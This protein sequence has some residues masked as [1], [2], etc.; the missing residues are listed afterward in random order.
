MSAWFRTKGGLCFFSK[1]VTWYLPY[2]L[3]LMTIW[4]RK[5]VLVSLWWVFTKVSYF[6]TTRWPSLK[7]VL[8]WSYIT[9]FSIF[10]SV[11]LWNTKSNFFDIIIIILIGLTFRIK[12]HPN[13]DWF[14]SICGKWSIC[15]RSQKVSE[16]NNSLHA[17]SINNICWI[18]N[19][20]INKEW[21]SHS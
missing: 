16:L 3:C 13:L 20:W 8:S 9:I 6:F 1:S 2:S 14:E 19:Q 10:I 18:K 7:H 4:A 11:L 21:K 15:N 5:S 12:F 17:I